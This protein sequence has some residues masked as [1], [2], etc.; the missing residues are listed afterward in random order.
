MFIDVGGGSTEITVFVD[1]K[2]VA[3]KSFDVGTIRLLNK[4]VTKEKWKE[5]KDWLKKE[6][7]TLKTFTL[8]G[9]GG[10][11]NRLSKMAELKQGKALA[12]GTLCDMVAQL[13]EFSIEDR[14]KL[15]D[16]NPDRADVIVPAGEI[17]IQLMKW[18]E[19]PKIFV[20]KIGLSD[21]LVREAYFEF[22][23]GKNNF[24]LQTPDALR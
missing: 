3:A 24:P 14:M 16:L 9:S 19:A 15:F 2:A 8:V 17:F 7:K 18:L 13:K 22:K 10:N 4:Q 21:G 23:S 11:I 6:T 5:L 20:P 12:F 1:K